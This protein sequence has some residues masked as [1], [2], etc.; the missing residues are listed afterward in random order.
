MIEGTIVN[1]RA[2]DMADLGRNHA[3]INDREVSRFLGGTARYLMSMAAEEAWMRGRCERLMSFDNTF[4]AIETK[5]GRH[6]GNTNLFNA[7][8]EERHAEFGIMIGDK[9]CWSQGFGT[10]ATRT[11]VRFG[12][13]EMNLQRIILQV[14]SYNPRAMACY[15][16]AGF[17]EEV[18]MRQDMWHEGAY[19]ETIVM[20][21]LREE[22]LAGER[23]AGR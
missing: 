11:L 20:G 9:D 3:W 15:R 16:K 17:I 22:F 21:V 5:D 18:R 19:Y 12:F 6:I 1:L 10:D 2:P 23:E 14:F 13:E 8:P 7:V 4:F